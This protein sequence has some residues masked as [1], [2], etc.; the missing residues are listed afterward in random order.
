MNLHCTK[1]T[2]MLYRKLYVFIHSGISNHNF[3][4]EF[5]YVDL[6]EG[7]PFVSIVLFKLAHNHVLFQECPS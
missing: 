6:S 2:H 4:C 1:H 5:I 3:R 7:V